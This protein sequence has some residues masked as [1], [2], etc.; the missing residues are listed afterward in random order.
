MFTRSVGSRRR[1]FRRG[2]TAEHLLQDYFSKLSL[3]D[4]LAMQ[5]ILQKYSPGVGEL[6]EPEELPMLEQ[7]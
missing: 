4:L 1:R 2:S 7:V 3:E 5:S 6:T